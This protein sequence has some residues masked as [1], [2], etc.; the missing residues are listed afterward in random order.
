MARKKNQA[1]G[2]AFHYAEED[3]TVLPE[4]DSEDNNAEVRQY[5]GAES[6]RS[7]GEGCF[8]RRPTFSDDFGF[9]AGAGDFD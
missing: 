3:L 1:P 9:G 2:S 4:Q 5:L 7:M 8:S 6:V